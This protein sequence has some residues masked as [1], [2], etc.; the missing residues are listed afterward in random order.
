MTCEL[1]VPASSRSRAYRG[2]CPVKAEWSH[3]GLTSRA[4]AATVNAHSTIGLAYD[5]ITLQTGYSAILDL[6]PEA[7][8]RMGSRRP[9]TFDPLRSFASHG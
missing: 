7:D 3:S 8:D 1:A 4:T 9:G 6:G 5:R 2:Q